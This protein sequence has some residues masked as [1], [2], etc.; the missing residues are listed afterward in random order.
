V[1]SDKKDLY[2]TTFDI[3]LMKS[4]NTIFCFYFI[5]PIGRKKLFVNCQ[6]LHWIK[7]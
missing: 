7:F 6:V 4:E 5:F 3:A 1:H 2:L